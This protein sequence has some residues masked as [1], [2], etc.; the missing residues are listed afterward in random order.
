MIVWT[1]PLPRGPG[2]CVTAAT[3]PFRLVAPS[4]AKEHEDPF[5]PPELSA[6]YQIGDLRQDA[7]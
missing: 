4:T 3:G 5:P 1:E 2:E 7:L 6:R